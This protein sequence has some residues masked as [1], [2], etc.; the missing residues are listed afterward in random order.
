[1]NLGEKLLSEVDT[2]LAGCIGGSESLLDHLFHAVL[3]DVCPYLVI[4]GLNEK[5]HT[6][7]HCR[8]NL[9][10]VLHDVAQSF[11]VS[12]R[13]A[14]VDLA[15]EAAG[16]LI[17]VV[18]RKNRKEGVFGSDIDHLAHFGEVE[19]YVVMREHNALRHARRTRCEY[20]RCHFVLV[21]LKVEICAVSRVYLFT[22]CGAKSGKLVK[23]YEIEGLLDLLYLVLIFGGVY[24]RIRFGDVRNVCDLLRR[25][26]LVY[27]DNNAETADNGHVGEC[28]CVAVFARD[29][30]TLAEKSSRAK[31][32]A[33]SFNIEE[34]LIEGDPFVNSVPLFEKC[35]LLGPRCG[36]C[37][38]HLLQILNGAHFVIL[39]LFHNEQPFLQYS[40]RITGS[41]PFPSCG[42]VY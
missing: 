6:E 37:V 9:F 30:N 27:R 28:P 33:E 39:I 10:H 7:D 18:E 38:E 22:S 40:H 32:G 1:M 20:E 21:Y 19:G 36:A 42:N 34:I 25:D 12:D 24:N 16:A 17:C 14:A 3:A 11:A 41:C 23:A 4:H 31:L 8:V 26:F 13:R 35:V 29:D 2:D 15:E 5:R